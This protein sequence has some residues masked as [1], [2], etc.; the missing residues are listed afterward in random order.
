MCNF[1]STSLSE[2]KIQV[3]QHFRAVTDENWNLL[4]YWYSQTCIL[5]YWM[6]TE[7]D[8]SGV[9]G[10][11]VINVKK[12]SYD[13][14]SETHGCPFSLGESKSKIASIIRLTHYSWGQ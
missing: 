8:E 7:I 6:E 4:L 5:S 10:T 14:R 11:S 13:N 9:K 2:D 3:S 12:T 1:K